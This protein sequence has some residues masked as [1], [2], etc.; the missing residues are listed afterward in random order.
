[1]FVRAAVMLGSKEMMP[2]SSANISPA[3]KG[4]E[5]GS[6]LKI[7]FRSGCHAIIRI[8]LFWIID[9][10]TDRTY[11]PVHSYPPFVN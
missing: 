6:R 11:V 10:P 9:I 1:V 4:I 2:F 7:P 5:Y 3:Q 8:T